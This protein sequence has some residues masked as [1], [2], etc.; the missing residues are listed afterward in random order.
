[1]R[2]SIADEVV[3]VDS[4]GR[5]VGTADRNGVHGPSTPRHLAFSCHVRDGDGLVLVTRRALTKR[6]WPGVWT[7]AFCGHPR[8]GEELVDA[9]VRR[10]DDELGLVLDVRPEVVLPQFSYRA[11]DDA[12]IEENELCPVVEARVS[13]GAALAPDPAEVAAWRWVEPARLSAAVEAAPWA[14][15]PW[16]VLQ[17]A[18]LGAARHA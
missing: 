4:D 16:L 2:T 12:G 10:A 18:E 11:I 8:P 3:L 14:F 5:P 15:S 1:V 17:Q 9:V 6:S 13:T 7:N